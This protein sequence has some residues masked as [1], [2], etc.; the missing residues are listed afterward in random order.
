MRVHRALDRL[1][2]ERLVTQKRKRWVLTAAGKKE[3]ER[4]EE[5]AQ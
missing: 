3:A 4:L 1:K 2:S 5:Q